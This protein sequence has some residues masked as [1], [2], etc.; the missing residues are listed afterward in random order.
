MIERG[1]T[2]QEKLQSLPQKPGV[3][4]MK[5][6]KEEIIYIGKASSLRNRVHS[7]FQSSV[8][9]SPRLNTLKRKIADF[10]YIVTDSEVEAL[11][12]EA[13]LI[14]Q[15]KPRYNVNLKDDKK[16]PYIA[17]SKEA[18]PRIYVTRKLK[19]DGTGYFGPYTD[20]K[21]MRRTLKTLHRIIP[22]RSCHW[23]L[24]GHHPPRA[25]LNFQIGH[26]TGPC[27][28]LISIQDYA[29][30]VGEA[31]LFLKGRS[32]EL[33]KALEEKME[34]A[35]RKLKFEIAAQFRD[36]LADLQSVLV[37]QKV[38][39][40]KKEDRD[41]IS[42]AREHNDAIGVVM[43]VRGGK[44][45]DRKHHHLHGVAG[46]SKEE[47]LSAFVRQFYLDA[48]TVPPEIHL[49]LQIEDESATTAWL[50]QKR[51]G[52]VRL[53]VPQRGNKTKLVNM[54]TKNAELLL[55]EWQLKRERTLPHSVAALQKDLRLSVLPRRIEAVDIS[56]I[57]GTDAVGSLVY[58][59]DGRP[60]KSEYRR[61]K[62]KTVNE[63]DDFAM[64]KEVV[65]RR[66]RGLKEQSQPLPDLL[67][68]DGGKGQLSSAVAALGELEISDQPVIGLA[69]KL[70]EVFLP[71]LSDPQN[72]SKTSASLKLLQAV[73]DEA[74][75]FAVSYHRKLR[76]KKIS[77]SVLDQIPGVGPARKATLLRD[78]GS[79][80][81]IAQ[82]SVEQIA[83]A[84]GISLQLAQ[85]IK[86]RLNNAQRGPSAEKT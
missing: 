29:R 68:V 56:N 86:G 52:K 34:E 74:H 69:K 14:K 15:H 21:A 58:F 64:V 40:L 53:C 67:V 8:P 46:F 24:P 76:G 66:F 2:I 50:S 49:P 7:Y 18:Y 19:D 81:Q 63:Q 25:C 84:K 20:V 36:R 30:L 47:M 28:G 48:V 55:T 42:I 75:R 62:I 5:S 85:I 82:I 59:Q 16:Y 35:S 43:E 17:I 77:R 72:I 44:L 71:G 83:Q 37:R 27:Q 38:F 61:F 73:R 57:G 33:V 31:R 11:I 80:K 45:L 12:L 4:L 65:Q 6:K 70:E 32:D 26:C 39:T 22:M 54:V 3:Y 23:D 10:N 78:F 41:I 51:G 1:Q 60:K 13:N 9:F 79:V